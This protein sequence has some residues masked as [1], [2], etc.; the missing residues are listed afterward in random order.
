MLTKIS[1]V[2]SSQ[3]NKFPC[4]S[5]PTS[6]NEAMSRHRHQPV[7]PKRGCAIYLRTSSE[8]A[9][10]PEN[11]QRRQRHTIEHSFLSREPMPVLGEY[12]DNLSGRSS[13]NRPDYQRMLA[14]A[15]AGLFSH[16]V[17]ENAER[18]GRN[19][20]EALTAID[21]LHELG[22][23]VR[24]A[25]Y[26][27]LDP[28]DPDDRIMVSL[29]FT[30]ARRESIKLGQRVRG[31][32]HAKLRNGGCSGLA[33]DGY[34]NCEERVEMD[35]S[36]HGRYR[37]WV[38]VDESR[39]MIWRTAWELLLTERY[40][41]AQI[42]EQFHALGYHYR[43]GRPFVTLDAQGRH[44]ANINTLA[45]GF[46]N[47]FY[48]GWVV[49]EK[50][51]IAPKTIRGLWTPLVSTE[52][53]ERG[54]SILAKRAEKTLR[55]RKHEY[56]LS[57]MIFLQLSHAKTLTRLICSTSNPSRPGGGTSHYRVTG[58]THNFLCT[59]VEDQLASYIANTR[60]EP[61]LLPLVK[62]QYTE[63]VAQK[64]GHRSPSE[65]QKVEVALKA[66]DAEEARTLRLF[67][68]GMVSEDNWRGLWAEW[69]D[70]RNTLKRALIVQESDTTATIAGLEDALHII[71][72]IDVHYE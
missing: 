3:I 39:A 64:L 15:R 52:D 57:G 12:I 54:L 23:A 60:I 65:K 25:D 21:E 70:R 7:Q 68:A 37:R 8:E 43:T 40:T 9:Q 48:A 67:A 41:L 53:F 55:Q 26:P 30:L 24:F 6:R 38:E 62:A 17:V 49:S 45:K 11:S 51:G 19:D 50:A 42:C 29:S 58:T 22:V 69:Q 34:I 66:I 16:V 28:I 71:S 36:L 72:K 1:P 35:K 46:H 44:F 61:D 63:E 10:N 20:T 27:D 32:L 47:W 31:G 18:F 33:P 59:E 56:L 4:I 2:A 14:D 13:H 5:P